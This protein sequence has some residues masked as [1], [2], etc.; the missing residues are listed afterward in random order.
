M[1]AQVFK[2][3]THG[4]VW[5]VQ[6]VSIADNVNDDV[7]TIPVCKLCGQECTPVL[8]GG[9]IEVWHAL[10]DEEMRAEMEQARDEDDE[11]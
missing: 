8:T 11:G 9:G 5:H 2:C 1:F 4:D 10:T 6:M 3:P 7:Y